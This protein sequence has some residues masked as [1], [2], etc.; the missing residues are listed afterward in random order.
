MISVT[1]YGFKIFLA[2][3]TQAIRNLHLY[4]ESGELSE[5]GYVPI[6]IQPSQWSDGKYPEQVWEFDSGEPVDV[7]GYYV[8]DE[9]GKLLYSE[10][11]QKRNDAGDVIDAP[12]LI[13]NNGDRIAVGLN[14]T[15]LGRG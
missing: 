5:H 14:L 1:P 10:A 2:A 13:K 11:F 3:Q 6:P 9:A 7:L 4:T 12:M 8:T 15:L